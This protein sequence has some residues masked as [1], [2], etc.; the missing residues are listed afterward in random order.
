MDLDSMKYAELRNRAK[1]LGLKANMKAD[2]LLKAIKKHYEQEKETEKDKVEEMEAKVTA[3]VQTDQSQE[4]FCSSSVFVNT[5]RG[6]AKK[7]RTRDS[8]AKLDNEGGSDVV[9]QVR[10]YKKRR[11]SSLSKTEKRG[12]NE[13]VIES[14]DMSSQVQSEPKDDG[15]HVAKPAKIPRYKGRQVKR[16]ALKPVTPNFQKLHEA[17]FNK[18]ESIDAYVQ[19][20]NNNK[21]KMEPVPELKAAKARRVSLFS[22]AAYRNKSPLTTDKPDPPSK[23]TKKKQDSVFKPSVLC[24]RRINVRFSELM[25]DNEY[26]RSLVK[27]PARYSSA[28]ATSTPKTQTPAGRKTSALSATKPSASFVFTGNTSVTP[29]TQKKAVFDLKASLSRPLTYKPHTGKLKPFSDCKDDKAAD[30]SLVADSRKKYYKQHKVQTREERQ[31]QQAEERKAK[32]SNLLCARRG[33]VMT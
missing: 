13:P 11:L 19:R 20:K 10:A 8:D 2:R 23:L 12:E 9:P 26:K 16:A 21:R 6:K 31:A 15:G 18:M 25:P 30:K 3:E 5:R 1:Q 27:T 33:L 7:T 28:L 22:P 29:G 14:S 4:V 24:T 17:H 32:K